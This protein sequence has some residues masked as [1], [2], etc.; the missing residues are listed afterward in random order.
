MS[1]S[2]HTTVKE[3]KGKTKKEIDEMV[4][5]PDSPLNELAEKRELKREIKKKRKLGKM[6][7]EL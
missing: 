3:L 1:K 4:N 2:I 7:N 6:N 5:G